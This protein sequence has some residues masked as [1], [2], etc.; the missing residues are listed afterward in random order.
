MKSKIIA[1]SAISA[2]FVAIIL[3]LGAYI[4][5]LDIGAVVLSSVFV[6]LP[7]YKK[8][9]LGSFLTFLVGGLIAFMISGFNI[10]SIVFPSYI[11]F[12]GVFPIIKALMKDKKINKILGFFIGL[13]WCVAVF[14]GMYFYFIFVMGGI[15]T[16]LPSWISDYILYA[17][18]AVSLIFYVV[19]DRFLSVTR[20]LADK[21]LQRIVK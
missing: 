16:G 2:S 5:L 1:L 21:Y 18:G 17:V 19:F 15:F 8:S 20:F 13:I 3:T 12:F 10:M 6:T 11:A 7:L 9:Y 4:E 14:Y